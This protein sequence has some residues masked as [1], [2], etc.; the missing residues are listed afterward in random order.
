MIVRCLYV[1]L[2]FA[3][4]SFSAAAAD[5]KIGPDVSLDSLSLAASDQQY[6]VVWRDLRNSPAVSI[7]G[8]SVSVTGVVSSDF[9]I[10]SA[11]AQ[12]LEGPVQRNTVAYDTLGKNFLVIWTD[13]RN[14]GPGIRGSLVSPSNTVVL[15]DILIATL[16]RASDNA[17]Q[18]IFNGSEFVVAW[19]DS[20]GSSGNESRISFTRVTGA[21]V[22]GPV[23]ALPYS[24]G[25]NQKLESVVNGPLGEVLILWQD[26]GST[27]NATYATRVAPDNSLIAPAEG[28]LLFKRDFSVTGF[29]APIGAAFDSGEYQILSSH[30][31]QIDSSV[32]KTRLKTDGALLRPSVPFVEVSQGVTGLAEDNFPR[33][34]YNGN[35]EFFFIR[36]IRVSD[37]A[38]HLMT[39]RVTTDGTDRDPNMALIDSA[40]Q[41]VLNGAMT[42]AIGTQ[43]LVVWMDGRRAGAQPD[44]QLNVYGFVAD[45][46]KKGDELLPYI[47]TVARAGPIV[48][49]SP[50]IVT[51]GNGGST[52]IID[53]Q[54]WEFGD[55]A[56]ADVGNTT[57]KYT[58]S[59]EFIA[60]LSLIRAGLYMR[61]FV[62]ISVDGDLLGGGGGPPEVVGGTPG[63][64]SAG[65]NTDV[66]VTSFNSV[67]NFT[68]N[69]LD[70]FRLTGFID[71]SKIPLTLADK[72]GSL[73]I[74]GKTYTFKLNAN[75]AYASDFAT[76]PNV[77]VGINLFN[78]VFAVQVLNEN[79]STAFTE[80]TNENVAQPGR[81]INV[82]F[83][84]SF[85]TVK[86]DSSFTGLYTAKASKSGRIAYQFANFGYPSSGFFRIFGS[87][88]KQNGK[89]AKVKAHSFVVTGNMGFGGRAGFTKADSGR[90]KISLGNFSE[91]IPVNA[92]TQKG[93]VYTYIGPKN[94]VGI[95]QFSYNQRSG[96][97]GVVLRNLPAEGD[98]PSGMPLSTSSFARADMAFSVDLDLQGGNA[99]Q[100]SAYARFVRRKS[101]AT[102]WT[103]R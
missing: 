83:T 101:T 27:P 93:E 47:K 96:L 88:A 13:N 7:R 89:D 34:F 87:L 103:N 31:A 42:A 43:Y 57:H 4:L 5:F 102:K 10:S 44:K 19:Q 81:E 65:V 32:F 75:G 94:K 78:G 74:G 63:P 67:L 38:Y 6:L 16:T 29:G 62:R 21:G 97:F 12:P 24:A 50:L 92:L 1:S 60:V 49:G 23:L 69:N 85:H 36:N 8:A 100:A 41:G 35:K 56:T 76:K 61:D 48:G 71:P 95:T 90:W 25:Q 3:L 68:Q 70:S 91:D 98:N 14:T 9:Q 37:I 59:G 80:A 53:S 64:V 46:T 54:L 40:S 79:L 26:L 33:V 82:P 52:G 2:L 58:R 86:L 99:F 66:V 84:F 28:T 18:V 11:A 45:G 39:K 15:D 17:P 73:V 72:E 77:S 55:G 22:A 30:G 51:F 20:A